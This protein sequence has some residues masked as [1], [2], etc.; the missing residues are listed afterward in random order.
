MQ[1]TKAIIVAKLDAAACTLRQKHSLNRLLTAVLWILVCSS[2]MQRDY[3]AKL[4]TICEFFEK[5]LPE[6]QVSA[7]SLQKPTVSDNNASI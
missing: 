5:E 1:S 2:D 7:A 4:R 6:I 3:Q